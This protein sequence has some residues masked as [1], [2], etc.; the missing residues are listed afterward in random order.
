MQN[1]KHWHSSAFPS[2][3]VQRL[4]ISTPPIRVCVRKLTRT[5]IALLIFPAWYLGSQQG[6]GT[7]VLAYVLGVVA[8]QLCYF[9]ARF[10]LLFVE[11]FGEK[12]APSEDFF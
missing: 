3:S 2:A 6:L 7:G 8:L 10:V 5:G 11:N 1:G 4:Q 12:K 9:V